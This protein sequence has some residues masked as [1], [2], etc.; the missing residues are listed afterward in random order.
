MNRSSSITLGVL[1]LLVLIAPV[2]AAQGSHFSEHSFRGSYA[3]G[4]IGTVVGVGPVAGTGLLTSDGRGNLVGT[5]TI[6]YGTGPC[7]LTLNGTYSVNHDG[8][9][10]GSVTVTQAVG[11]SLCRGGSGS[12]VNFSF[13]LSGSPGAADK[14]KLSETSEGFAILAQGERQ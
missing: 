3:V 14:I 13:V 10:T 5:E 12:T 7:A 9:G 4:I 11:E 8:T 1:A 2:A 6:S